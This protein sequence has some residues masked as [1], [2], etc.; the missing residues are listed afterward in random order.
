MNKRTVMEL[1]HYFTDGQ[2]LVTADRLA[3]SRNTDA[4]AASDRYFAL[5]SFFGVHG[6]PTLEEAAADIARKLNE[7]GK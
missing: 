1:A 5:R 3:R 4:L 2:M 6:A 7:E